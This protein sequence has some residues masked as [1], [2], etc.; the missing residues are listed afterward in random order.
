[1]EKIYREIM[2]FSF[3]NDRTFLSEQK[4]YLSGIVMAE[5]D[6]SGSAQ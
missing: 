1:M 4:T 2:F 5:N 6:V 3:K